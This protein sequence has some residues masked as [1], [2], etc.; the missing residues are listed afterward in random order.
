MKIMII[1]YKKKAKKIVKIT[2]IMKT[3]KKVKNKQKNKKIKLTFF[4]S[5]YRKK[6]R[7]FDLI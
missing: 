6:I 1:I 7:Y 5:K 2:R 4:N 3:K